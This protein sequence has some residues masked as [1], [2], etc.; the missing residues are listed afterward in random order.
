M[1]D[2]RIVSLAPRVARFAVYLLL[3]FTFMYLLRLFSPCD[4]LQKMGRIKYEQ[5]LVNL[6]NG[7]FLWV[8]SLAESLVEIV[9]F[10]EP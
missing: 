9:R 4:C 6:N 3:G 1:S 5:K 2:L 8:A 10:S 7:F